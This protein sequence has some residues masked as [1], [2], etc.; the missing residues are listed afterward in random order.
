MK[1]TRNY[2]I[3]IDASPERVWHA[4]WNKFEYPKWVSAFNA[5][6]YFN[7]DWKEGS[8]IQFLDPNGAGIYAKILSNK[9]LAEMT[10]EHQAEVKDFQNQAIVPGENSWYGSIEKYVLTTE[11]NMCLLNVTID[12]MDEYADYFDETFP[13][14]LQNIKTQSEHCW[15]TIETL[16]DAP[17]EKA[18]DCYTTPAHICKWNAASD[19]WHTTSAA[20]D[21]SVGGKFDYRMEAKDGSVGF[22][23][24]GTHTAIQHLES[25][26]TT[27]GDDRKMSATFSQQN[28]KV[29][30]L[31]MFEPENENAISIQEMG[32][33]LILN[34][35]KK[36]VESN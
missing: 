28:N 35:F 4:L 22:N 19:D 33:Q 10:F 5:G 12:V 31:Q 3:T 32:W 18:W 14:A 6:A 11:N 21:V 17:L 27:L 36:Y 24:S 13:K 26:A 9:P 25:I 1:T 16:I 30:L 15:I 8:M 7:T 29:H 2:S 20:N 23:F 34:N